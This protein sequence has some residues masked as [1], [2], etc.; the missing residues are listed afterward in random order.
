MLT[1]WAGGWY[2]GPP[3]G[4]YMVISGRVRLSQ[5][6]WKTVLKKRLQC[7]VTGYDNEGNETEEMF[8]PTLKELFEI[9]PSDDGLFNE[10]QRR[11]TR[12]DYDPE[13]SVWTFSV[14]LHDDLW[15]DLSSGDQMPKQLFDLLAAAKDGPGVDPAVLFWDVA[16]ELDQVWALTPEGARRMS[17][18]AGEDTSK[19]LLDGRLE[20]GLA[21]LAA[22]IER[23]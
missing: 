1:S 19:L 22:Q 13:G 23:E 6:A 17:A 5:G 16:S 21:K 15:L 14:P 11:W 7:Q 8:L 20:E 3:M 9:E 18:P 4:E 2:R 10:I 12:N